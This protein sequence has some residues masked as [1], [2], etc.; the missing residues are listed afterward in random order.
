MEGRCDRLFLQQSV[1]G[2][3]N[4]LMYEKIVQQSTVLAKSRIPSDGPFDDV[5]GSKLF[6]DDTTR[7]PS[8]GTSRRP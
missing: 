1:E 6:V 4:G 2:F 3:F 8:N 5:G 7:A